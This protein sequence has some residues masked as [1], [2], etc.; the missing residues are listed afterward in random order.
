MSLPTREDLYAALDRYCDAL[1]AR[2]HM[3]LAW[4]PNALTTENNVALTPG[5]GLWGTI[6]G[7]GAYDLRFA[8][9]W[10][11]QVALFTTVEET[12]ASSAACIRIG[13]RGEAIA[14]VETIV[15][16]QADEALVFPDPKFERKP[17]MEQEV[18]P[19]QRNDRDTMIA[20]AD[21]YF[22]T[23]EKN[24]GT[25]RTKFHPGCNR[26]ENGVQTTNNPDFFV[27]VAHLSCEEQ[28]RQGNYRYDDR[29]RGRRF[30][31]VDVERGI[32]L[33]HGFIDHC[34]KLG[35]YELT[36]GTRVTSPI[37]RPH[38]FC[39]SE[40]FKIRQGAIEQIE[41]NFITVPYHMPSPWDS[42]W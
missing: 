6:T 39:L 8:D 33:A 3:R 11:S 19:A 38:T 7:R 2:D 21:G 10:N 27:P 25:I 22:A 41:A 35:E 4:A 29:L 17:V 30:P 40:A 32:V 36:D 26:I 16:R 28:F 18:P 9:V 12:N 13:L 15:V 20:L 42:R 1:L 24:D 34:G 14:E 23:L 37:R 5:D 31:L